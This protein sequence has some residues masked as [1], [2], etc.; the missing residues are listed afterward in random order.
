MSDYPGHNLY[1]ERR[2]RPNGRAS[3]PVPSER[4]PLLSRGGDH[5][6]YDGAP[7]G[8]RSQ[9]KRCPKH[10]W[11]ALAVGVG[12]LAF[13]CIYSLDSLSP[14]EYGLVYNRVT[15]KVY[16]D[17]PYTHGRHFIGPTNVFLK[18]PS[19][20]NYIE[21]SGNSKANH[22]AIQARTGRDKNDPDSGGQSIGISVAFTYQLEKNLL[23]KM[24]QSFAMDY[25]YRYVQFAMQ[26]IS[27]VTQRFHPAAFWTDRATVADTMQAELDKVLRTQ[28][29]ARVRTLQLLRLEFLPAYEQTIVG[30]QLAIQQRTTN[31]YRQQVVSVLKDIDTQ[32]SVTTASIANVSA[33]AEAIAMLNQNSAA[34]IAFNITQHAKAVSYAK[35]AEGLG[36]S[37]AALILQYIRVRNIR[38]HHSSNLTIALEHPV[39]RLRNAAATGAAAAAAGSGKGAAA[40]ALKAE[41]ASKTASK[42]ASKAKGAAASKA[43]AKGSKGAA[44]SKASSKKG[45]DKKQFLLLNTD[46]DPAPPPPYIGGRK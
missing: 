12:L 2:Q 38:Q 45:N 32:E 34:A 11:P 4:Q 1:A 26:S 10:F 5:Y 13:L 20:Y 6:N 40:A 25:E 3:V 23:G 41:D 22:L 43:K 46:L 9:S 15:G 24:Y 27:D 37:T 18:F 31:E 21:F 17:D 36:M 39:A 28:G 8:D 44:A 7:A 16:K 35:F 30:I 42:T 14:T 33:G 29:Y 19:I